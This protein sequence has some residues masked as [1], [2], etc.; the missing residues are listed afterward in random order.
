MKRKLVSFILVFLIAMTLLPAN[1]IADGE[2]KKYKDVDQAKWYVPYVDFVV[3]HSLMVG[4]SKEHFAP[5]LVV[6]RA[7]FVQTLYAMAEKPEVKTQSEFADVKKSAYYFDAVNWAN[8]KHITAGTTKTTFSPNQII[9]REQA[10]TFFKA[11][12]D[13]ILEE[14]ADSK[15]LMELSSYPDEKEISKYA[16]KAMQWAVT[17]KLITGVQKDKEIILKPK[18]VMT[19]AQLATML[20]AFDKYASSNESEDKE[21]DNKEADNTD[22]KD[23]E[24]KS[25]D[26]EDK[27]NHSGNDNDTPV[28]PQ[29]PANPTEG[30]KY[31]WDNSEVIKVTNVEDSNNIM[32]EKEAKKFLEKRGFKD[33]M[34]TYEYTMDGNSNEEV[35]ID[36]PTSTKHPMYQAYYIASSGD[37]WTIFI[38][39]GVLFANPASFNLESESGA[40][41]LIS[42]S[43]TLTSYENESNK[44]YETIPKASAAIVK[45]ID[46]IDAD[47]L[48]ILTREEISKL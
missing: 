2:S 32:T 42:E 12:A 33:V 6:T 20:K 47:T 9:S 27:D 23:D 24:K 5:N 25:S 43:K 44:Y 45:Q 15:E 16:V 26:K 19:R 11:Y 36:N 4:I 22:K 7:Q 34:L 29:K 39:D 13:N 1:S 14:I 31:Y 28:K 8:E 38:I 37:V 30:E 46:R 17:V 10:A 40:Q 48:D 18:G 3:E 21:T 41:L 35:E